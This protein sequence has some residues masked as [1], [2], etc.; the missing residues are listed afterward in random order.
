LDD[1]Q[2]LDIDFKRG[3]SVDINGNETILEVEEEN[4]EQTL[5]YK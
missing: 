3:V 1:N 4:E 2:T 5:L